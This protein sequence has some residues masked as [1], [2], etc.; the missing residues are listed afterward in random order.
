MSKPDVKAD[1]A[2][3]FAKTQI[4]FFF[5]AASPPSRLNDFFSSLRLD[6]DKKS[7]R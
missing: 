7:S 3:M 5:L 4:E 1:D 2:E 6:Q